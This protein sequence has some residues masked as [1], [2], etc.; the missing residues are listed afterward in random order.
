MERIPEKLI[1][2]E[3]EIKSA[4]RRWLFTEHNIDEDITVTF[5]TR[6]VS[7]NRQGP[8]RDQADVT[9]I[10]ATVDRQ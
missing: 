6:V 9:I 2:T 1:L 8:Y 7:G 4:I 5:N 3:E 10:T